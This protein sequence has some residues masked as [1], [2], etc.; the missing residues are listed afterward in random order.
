MLVLNVKPTGI[1]F[2]AS[3]LFVCHLFQVSVIDH[4]IL[5]GRDRSRNTLE[6]ELC[7]TYRHRM[8]G[9]ILKIREEGQRTKENP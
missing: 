3:S 9:Y 6:K 7:N 8:L 5:A 1:N 2:T 4:L